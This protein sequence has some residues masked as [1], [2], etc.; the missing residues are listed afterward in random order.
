MNVRFLSV[1]ELDAAKAALW[2]DEQQP[3]LGDQFFAEL[4]HGINR[5]RRNPFLFPRLEYY[6]GGLDVRRG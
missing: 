1:A 2:Y 3:G 5:V 6:N 4:E